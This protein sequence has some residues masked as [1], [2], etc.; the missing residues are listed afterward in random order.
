MS[1]SLHIEIPGL[2]AFVRKYAGAGKIIDD[3]LAKA[4][5]RAGL[6]VEAGAKRYAPV[7]TGNLRRSITTKTAGRVTVVGTNVQYARV[8][9]FGRGAGTTPPPTAPIAAWLSRHGGDPNAAYVVARAIG[10]RGIAGRSYLLKAFHEL[11]PKIRAEFA[12][13][14]KRVIARLSGGG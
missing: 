5:Q 7:D 6:A 13:V 2:A 14:P 8:V 9:E 4:G 1:D 11:T 3:E 12:Q 10:R